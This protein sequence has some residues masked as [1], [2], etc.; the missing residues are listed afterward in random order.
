M[1]GWCWMAANSACA[2]TREVYVWQRQFTPAVYQ[3]IEAV[4][5]ETDGYAVLAAEV[6]WEKDGPRL[7]RSPVNYSTL[8]AAGRPVGLVLRIGP[9]AG[10]FS[11]D[12][13][14]ASY[15]AKVATSLMQASRSRGFQPAELQVDFDCASSKL[16]GY[17]LWLDALRN[18]SGGTKITFTALPDWL[19]RK[20]FWSLAHAADGFIL[21]VHSL[22]KP[23]GPDDVFQLCDPDR[24]WK[25]IEQAGRVG[26]SFRVALPTYG[27]ELAFDATGKFIALSAEG[28]PPSM[29]S[30]S[31]TRTVRSD[32]AA[33][34]GLARKIAAA[35]PVG[36]AGVIWFRL[37][38]A[39]DRLNWNIATLKVVLRD[40]VPVSLLAAT[41]AWSTDGLAEVAL[42]NRGEQDEPLPLKVTAH[43][44]R[45]VEAITAD[46]LGAYSVS[47]DRAEAGKLVLTP[48]PI[49][50]A[51]RI[52]PGRSRKIGW[53]RFS[54]EIPLT[55]QIVARR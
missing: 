50:D 21:Q 47:L 41:V 49:A 37:P 13:A 12:D 55:L 33:V 20:E 29:P 39:G 6:S 15:L 46:G 3:A 10:P 17:R 35:K 7:F 14:T 52:A 38:V 22:E 43:W 36:C 45:D 24:A 23:V 2:F 51:E 16:G 54:H 34:A 9:Y 32:V 25:W 30:G 27:Y 31:Q 5:S 48:K 11:V 26:V 19:A 18:A 53:F 42:V 28:V 40:E 8:A 4:R 1:L 44:S